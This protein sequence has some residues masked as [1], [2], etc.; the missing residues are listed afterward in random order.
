MHLRSAGL[1]G[2]RHQSAKTFYL[3]RWIPERAMSDARF[4]PVVEMSKVVSYQIK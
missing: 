2:S 1:V 4:L 3:I